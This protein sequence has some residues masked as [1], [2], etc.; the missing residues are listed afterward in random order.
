MSP[1]ESSKKA[2]QGP[3]LVTPSGGNRVHND[4]DGLAVD[5]VEDRG[6]ESTPLQYNL[7]SMPA[8]YTLETLHQ[9]WR[10]G[11]IVIP[12]F[13][14]GYV[15]KAPQASKLIESFLMGLPVPPV[16][17]ATDDDERSV[18]IDG[19]QRLKTIFSYLDGAY[20]KNS[21][22]KGKKFQI[23]G[24]NENSRLYGKTF[25]DLGEDDQRRLKN[26]V[27]RATIVKQN[28][29][30]ND[31]SAIYEIFERLNT[32]GTS[33]EAQ[34][35]RNCVYMGSLNEL[36]GKLNNDKDWR[37]ILGKPH[38]DPRMKDREMILRYMA[39]FHEEGGYVPTMKNFL[40]NFMARYKN[41]DDR[42]LDEEERRFAD[43]TRAVRNTL[44]SKPFNN[45]RGQLRVPLFDSIFVAFARNIGRC[46]SDVNKR[47]SRLRSD[48][49]F[50][51]HAGKSTTS[52]GAIKGRLAR[53][54]E[55]LFE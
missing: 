19:M 38:H 6:G 51:K 5:E 48:P 47:F 24:I 14:R 35:V 12:R 8:D 42:F 21:D 25:L 29:P 53:A 50:I 37:E 44:G 22:F 52:A 26:A 16:F 40:S 1:A 9:K 49:E 23:V 43:V 27:L 33:L 15:W 32:G 7:F 10:N 18:V 3:S 20:P 4:E 45:E 2:A 46:P 13:Q 39:L 41:P 34:E 28:G 17:L 36:L 30:P 55:I 54:Q 11:D 31:N